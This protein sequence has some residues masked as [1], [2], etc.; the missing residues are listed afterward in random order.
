M[1][2]KIRVLKYKSDWINDEKLLDKNIVYHCSRC[3]YTH[4]TK[5]DKIKLKSGKCVG[6]EESKKR[7]R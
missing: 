3:G 6:C 2:D 5:A 4:E 1:V 7:H